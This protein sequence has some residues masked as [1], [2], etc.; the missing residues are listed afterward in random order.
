MSLPTF[1]L[2]NQT[3]T[4]NKGVSM[5][6]I[7]N[8]SATAQ[9]AL[10]SAIVPVGA[11]PADPSRFAWS[12]D[13]ILNNKPQRIA[14]NSRGNFIIANGSKVSTQYG[15]GTLVNQSLVRIEEFVSPEVQAYVARRADVH[16]NGLMLEANYW[17]NK[18]LTDE[19]SGESAP[20]SFRVNAKELIEAKLSRFLESNEI[21]VGADHLEL[22][23]GSV[24]FSEC[25]DPRVSRQSLQDRETRLKLRKEARELIK[26]YESQFEDKADEPAWL[27]EEL[28]EDF[29]DYF[30]ATD[31]VEYDA[32]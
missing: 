16:N 11:T 6:R 10:I 23:E 24:I 5:T 26:S 17:E 22:I 18:C 1:S 30:G 7:F 2:S 12:H 14:R 13:F 32:I 21:N 27:R 9:F 19:D 28:N 3:T 15:I 29:G 25:P 8:P 31:V 4:Q 20:R